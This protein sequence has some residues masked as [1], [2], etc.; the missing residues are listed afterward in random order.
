MKS[1]KYIE[2]SIELGKAI[3]LAIENIQKYP[4]EHFNDAHIKQ[5]VE[6]YLDA[7]NKALN[8]K[9]QYTKLASLKYVIEDV[10]IY[11]NEVNNEG[12]NI[13]WKKIEE[14][15]LPFKRKNRLANVLRKRKIKNIHDYNHVMDLIAPYTQQG[16]LSDDEVKLLNTLIEEFEQR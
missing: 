6:F 4:P 14:N 10:F 13:F 9:P 3:D 12:V 11:F 8:P 1:K 2:K 7:K 16:L 5:F 15:S